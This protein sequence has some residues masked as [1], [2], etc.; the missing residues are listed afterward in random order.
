MF[1]DSCFSEEVADYG[2]LGTG[3]TRLKI[4]V[5]YKRRILFIS[6]VLQNRPSIGELRFENG[7]TLCLKSRTLETRNVSV[8]VWS[9]ELQ[10]CWWWQTEQEKIQHLLES[11]R[12]EDVIALAGFV[13]QESGLPKSEYDPVF[14]CLAKL[15]IQ[16][17][18]RYLS[19]VQLQRLTAMLL[20]AT[21]RNS[22][23]G[24][25]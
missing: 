17:R 25:L 19:L 23:E 5:A 8:H 14:A 18:L 13:A 16:N 1:E 2:K 6:R 10:M 9:E 4:V 15:E 20:E 22:P 11:A 3:H 12:P 21:E 7:K 24:K